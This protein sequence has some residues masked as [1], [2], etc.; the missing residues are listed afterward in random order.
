MSHLGKCEVNNF[1]SH[2]KAV[3]A[4]F[5]QYSSEIAFGKITHSPRA[6]VASLLRGSENVVT[7]SSGF[8][9]DIRDLTRGFGDK[10][11]LYGLTTITHGRLQWDNC[12]RDEFVAD[13]GKRS[14][15]VFDFRSVDGLSHKQLVYLAAGVSS[16]VVAGNLSCIPVN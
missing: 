1:D 8:I 10:H 2:T 11:I 4:V 16:E 14:S 5:V 13:G 12:S 15:F 7:R 9:P 3:A 6:I